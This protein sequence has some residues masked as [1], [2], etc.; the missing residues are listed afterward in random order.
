MKEKDKTEFIKWYEN[1]QDNEFNFKNKM[2]KYS[3]S[4]VEIWSCRFIIYWDLFLKVARMDPFQ[5]TT[6]ALVS[7]AIYKSEWRFTKNLK[8][9][10]TTRRNSDRN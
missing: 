5:Y 9:M 10:F 7:T 2:Y 6:V 3:K 4:D 1:M 8:K